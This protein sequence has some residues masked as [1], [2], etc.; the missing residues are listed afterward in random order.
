MK[1]NVC[2]IAALV[3]VASMPLLAGCSLAWWLPETDKALT[4][5]KQAA[6]NEREI[7]AL[8]RIAASL[9][10]M[11]ARKVNTANKEIGPK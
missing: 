2:R 10:R 1:K 11:E 3:A 6:Q 8:E 5:R 9:E 4:E 7:A